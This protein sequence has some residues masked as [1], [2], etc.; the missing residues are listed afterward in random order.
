ML[1]E[2]ATK[3]GFISAKLLNK[4]KKWSREDFEH[5]IK[6]LRTKG[7]LWIDK[8]SPNNPHFYFLSHLGSDFS[9]FIEFMKQY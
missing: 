4:E 3:Y 8:Q 6:D 1:L 7:I 9:K 5:N 2:L